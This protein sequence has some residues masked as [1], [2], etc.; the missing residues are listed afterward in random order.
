[1]LLAGFGV[2]LAGCDLE[3]LNPGA[4]L[5]K[6]LDT[7]ELMPIVVN[8]VSAEFNDVPDVLSYNLA[9]LTDDMSGT[10]S[11]FDTGRFR[12][13]LHDEEDSQGTWEQMH[14]AAWA[15]GEAWERLNEVLGGDAARSVDSAKLFALMGHAHRMLGE[16]FCDMAYDKGPLQPRTA[17]FDSAIAAFDQAITIGT[18]GGASADDWVTSA[19]AGRAQAYVGLG[20]WASAVAEASQVPT[21]FVH[22]A[23]YADG[24]NTNIVWSE[25]H[26]RAELGVWA[27]PAQSYGDP[28]GMNDPRTPY[29]VCGTWDDPENIP[30]PVTT[31]G[32]CGDS[33]SGAHQGA[34]GV[35]AHYRQQKHDDRGSDIP[36]ASGVEMR[37]IE[38]EAALLDDDLGTF[39]D[40]I[41]DVREFYGLADLPEPATA[42]A[43]E[44]PNAMDALAGGDPADDDAWSILD[45]ERYMTLWIE[46]RRLWDLWRWDHPFLAGGTLIGVGANPRASCMRI[47]RIECTL[48]EN[49]AGSSACS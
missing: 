1:M 26:G 49:L 18:A 10:G 41:N 30:S 5:D 17:A 2:L 31:T 6:D 14:E 19:H 11:Y 36:V 35:S 37:L 8:G 42:G 7:P 23:I 38:A 27:S 13:G 34:D 33:G 47:P 29:R 46:G 12:R 3:V 22:N 40:R 20:N 32:T 28:S 9:R 4:I 45:R 16:N 39:I 48:N 24:A 15:A 43:L 25:S 44:F 21:D